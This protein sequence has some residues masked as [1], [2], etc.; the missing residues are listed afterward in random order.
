LSVRSFN[1][2]FY[3]KG[4]KEKK[5]NNLDTEIQCQNINKKGNYSANFI[6]YLSFLIALNYKTIT[7]IS[8]KNSNRN[9]TKSKRLGETKMT[10]FF[11]KKWLTL[12][13]SCI[14]LTSNSVVQFEKN[15]LS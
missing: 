6:D 5:I 11:E 7:K 9:N 15:I 2:F 13:F 4:F 10:G 1:H 14:L 12:I 3:F 8:N